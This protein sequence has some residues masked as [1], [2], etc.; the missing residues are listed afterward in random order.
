MRIEQLNHRLI[1]QR[2]ATQP[3]GSGR[4][5]GQAWA[6]PQD[7]ATV[8]AH[9][10]NRTG[11]ELQSG[12]V[13]AATGQYDVTIRWRPDISNE[14]RF[15]WRSQNAPDRHLYITHAP[16]AARSEFITLLCEENT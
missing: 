4:S 1:L 10:Q 12:Q 9:I 15:A 8:W 13:V 6:E 2:D 3:Q 5:A 16:I 14:S 11:R 7:V